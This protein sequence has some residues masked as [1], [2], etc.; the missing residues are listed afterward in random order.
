M[1][2]GNRYGNVLESSG[3]YELEFLYDDR[4]VTLEPEL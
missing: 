2:D 1:I 3:E 4:D